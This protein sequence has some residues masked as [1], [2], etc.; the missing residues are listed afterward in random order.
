MLHVT[1]ALAA[2]G[3]A[4]AMLTWHCPVYNNCQL[5]RYQLLF[6]VSDIRKT[7]RLAPTE[8]SCEIP[9]LVPGAN[10]TFELEAR[11]AGILSAKAPQVEVTMPAKVVAPSEWIISSAALTWLEPLS[12]AGS[13]GIVYK[14]KIEGHEGHAAAKKVAVT[15]A[16]E[17]EG[18]ETKMRRE[19]RALQ[20]AQHPNVVHIIGVVQDAPTYL[21]LLMEMAPLGSLRT[22]LDTTAASIL[23]SEVAQLSL[24]AGTAAGM[25]FLHAQDPPILHHDL[26]T[27]NVLVFPDTARVYIAKIT[28]FGMAT[29]SH[30]STMTTTKT[31]VGAGT[32]AYMAPECFR[33]PK[34]GSNP[35]TTASEVYAFAICA[36]EVLTAK[37]PWPDHDLAT[38]T[39]AIV[40]D[41][42]RPD[43]PT[44]DELK[45]ASLV[46]QSL[47]AMVAG[48]GDLPYCW[49]QDPRRRPT[50]SQIAP[51]LQQAFES[52]LRNTPHAQLLAAA[53][54]VFTNFYSK[55]YPEHHSSNSAYY[56]DWAPVHGVERPNHGLANA[57]RKAL[58]VD[59]VIESIQRWSKQTTFRFAPSMLRTMQVARR[60][61]LDEH[62]L[63]EAIPTTS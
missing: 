20:Q 36:W 54:F 8:T 41:E 46:T 6:T 40:L 45:A 58:F 32:L 37:Q 62:R 1:T 19:F 29:G 9:H 2:T 5:E 4:T 25:A 35:F 38:L 11:A 27:E 33:K 21:G 18:L 51:V 50:F 10:Y 22:L 61:I 26:K 28:D 16:S 34:D 44:S 42:E 23:G 60:Y 53:N 43:S 14:V 3:M 12:T 13:T 63:P 31:K 47:W 39:S 52:H 24:L 48:N 59:L 56:M 17:R 15:V 49:A 7:L 30:G 57:M 55:P